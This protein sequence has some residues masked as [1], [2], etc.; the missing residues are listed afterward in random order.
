MGSCPSSPKFQVGA[1]VAKIDMPSHKFYYKNKGMN[2]HSLSSHI[3]NESL[4]QNYVPDKR[5]VR[6]MVDR[7]DHLGYSLNKFEKERINDAD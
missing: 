1:H 5:N 7:S 6:H 2:R 3:L 4:G